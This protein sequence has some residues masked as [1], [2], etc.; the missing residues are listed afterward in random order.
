M[1]TT[2]NYKE[3]G[4]GLRQIRIK[5]QFTFRGLS[6]LSGLTPGYIS[7]IEKGIVFPNKKTLDAL[8]SVYGE[9]TNIDLKK[10]ILYY[11][12]KRK[13]PNYFNITKEKINNFLNC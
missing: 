5:N 10:K 2:I 12:L 7:N 8:L 6:L 3:L 4:K 9:S 11:T 13:L 1:K